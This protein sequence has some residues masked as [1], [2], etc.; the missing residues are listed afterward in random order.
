MALIGPSQFARGPCRIP[1]YHANNKTGVGL[2]TEGFTSLLLRSPFLVLNRFSS[3]PST[4]DPSCDPRR[5]CFVKTMSAAADDV[6][7]LAAGVSLCKNCQVLNG[8]LDDYFDPEDPKQGEKRLGY[9]AHDWLPGLP[10]L[11]KSVEDG[12]GF[13]RLLWESILSE[14]R[15]ARDSDLPR[16]FTNKDNSAVD[17]SLEYAWTE[18]ARCHDSSVSASRAVD[19]LAVFKREYDDTSSKSLADS[20]A[21]LRF[22]VGG[23]G[24]KSALIYNLIRSG[25]PKA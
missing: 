10:V 22:R 21:I 20:R 9:H 3:R 8:S 17:L 16:F 24:G 4:S 23:A 18:L 14:Q 2:W 1:T 13:C 25:V 11:R 5:A 15:S 6:A 19:L 12:C 7:A